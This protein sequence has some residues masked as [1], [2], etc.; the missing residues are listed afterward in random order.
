MKTTITFFL[1]ILCLLITTILTIEVVQAVNNANQSYMG[2]TT[3][4]LYEFKTTFLFTAFVL[5]LLSIVFI[6][7]AVY[8]FKLF[9]SN[10]CNIMKKKRDNDIRNQVLDSK[11]D[12]LYL[13]LN[14]T[15][16]YEE[17]QK[18]INKFFHPT[19][20]DEF[21][22]KLGR[23]IDKMRRETMTTKEAFGSKEVIDPRKNKKQDKIVPER[24]T[25]H[26]EDSK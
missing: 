19:A 11:Y 26:V 14:S 3:G 18:I 22:E 8:L 21:K 12:K 15:N 10:Y 9:Y 24:D 1:G 2:N 25:F 4:E 13:D 5:A 17:K 7:H 16:I 20:T 23:W 6:A